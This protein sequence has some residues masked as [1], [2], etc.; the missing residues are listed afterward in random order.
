MQPNSQRQC[1]ETSSHR[2]VSNQM[3]KIVLD[4]LT[5]A[6]PPPS[7]ANVLA[8]RNLDLMARRQEATVSTAWRSGDPYSHSHAR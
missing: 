3:I 6:R 2:L 1:P 7:L 5:E 8:H 4:R